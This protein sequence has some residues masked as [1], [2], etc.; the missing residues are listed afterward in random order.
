MANLPIEINQRYK[1]STRIDSSE[2]NF[3]DFINGFILHGTAINVLGTIS[4]EYDGSAQR[5]YTLTGPYGSGK[6]TIALFLASLLSTDK[7]E[8]S[9]AQKKIKQSNEI[10]DF[11]MKFKVKKGWNIVKHVCGLESPANSILISIYT[12]FEIEFNI[13][14]IR[15]LSDEECLNKIKLVVADKSSPYDG[16]FLLIDEMGKALDYQSRNNKDLYLF[17]ELADIAQAAKLPTLIMG[18]LHQSFSDYAKNKD[19]VTQKEWAKVQGR[20]RDIGFNPSI[21]ESLVLVG[22]SISKCASITV[23]LEKQNMSLVGNVIHAFPSQNRNS[24]ALL[25]TLPLDPLVSLLLGP[26]SRRR[27]SQ[28][29]R[30]LFGFLASHERFGF[31][32]FLDSNYKHVENEL[33]LYHPERLW[34]YLHHNLHHLIVTSHDSKAWLEGCDAIYRA[35][36]KGL[37][38][39]VLVTKF[40]SLLTIFGFQHHLHA[41]KSLV[42]QY[43]VARSFE[44]KNVQQAI[45]DLETWSIVIYRPKHDA[46]FVFQ[47]SDIDINALVLERIEAISEGVDWTAACDVS[48]HVLATSH[49]HQTGTMRWAN[50]SLAS[51]IDDL[52]L[53]SLTK[54]PVTGQPFLTFVL[55]ANNTVEKALLDGVDKPYAVIGSIESLSNLKSVAIELIALTH[56]ATNEAKIAHDLIAKNELET[57]IISAKQQ[58]SIE[59]NLAFKNAKWSYSGVSLD[60]SPLTVIASDIANKI[61]YKSPI[62]LNELVNRSKPSGSANSA[63]R[64]LL[65]AMLENGD[66]E[67][68]GFDDNLF[69][70]EKGLY[71]SCLKSK[72]WHCSTDEGYLF[73]SEWSEQHLSANPRMHALWEEGFEFIKSSKGMVTLD[74]LYNL[75]MRP[76]YGLTAGLCRI[77]G[78]ALLKSLEGKIAFYD[79]DSTKSFIFIPE[80]DE[81][82]VNKIYKHPKEAAVRF[83]EI[84]AIQT[85]LIET[86]A[87]ATIG[88]IKSDDAVL[89]IAKHIVKIIHTLPTWVKKTSGDGF[90]KDGSEGG[91][92]KEA[93]DFRNKVIAANDPYKLIIEDL[94]VI[95]NINKD[96]EYSDEQLANKLKTAIEDLSAQHDM[97]LS[98]FKSIILNSLSAEFD[99]RLKARCKQVIK[100]AKRPNVKELASRIVKFIDGKSPFEF[101]INLSTGVPERSWTDKRLSSGLDELHNLCIQFRRIESFGLLDSKSTSQPLSFMTADNKGNQKAYSGF[102]KFELS[103]DVEVKESLDTVKSNLAHLSKEQQLATLANLLSSLMDE[104]VQEDRD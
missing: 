73:P 36:Q 48:Q 21:D 39:H 68:L 8:R 94:P 84:S 9:F 79:Y 67:D 30:S 46:L 7:K 16:M 85:H 82:L 55:P 38:L 15:H 100:A 10:A 23:Q 4:R 57:R 63:I 98:G 64:K 75:W 96:A 103:D 52:L 69:P 74:E 88:T 5:A 6:S 35:E 25:K 28:N 54:E 1:S 81:E 19:A 31:R 24:D 86:I 29:E 61:F 45:T 50:L 78:L 13:D 70:P 51:S 59:L 58:I 12:A 56:L 40:I 72:G 87:K 20:Y 83:F 102:I 62:V 90:Y 89:G 11:S 32:E 47:G 53:D 97:L 49:Y 77:Y 60:S 80:L 41:S 104:E 34:D 17:Q 66:K 101:I 22:D 44:L 27:F 33:A 18:F 76:P 91:L 43:F 26:I 93:R 3:K 65:Y 95:F 99:N 92:T 2:Y 71:L 14:D 42:E 37:E